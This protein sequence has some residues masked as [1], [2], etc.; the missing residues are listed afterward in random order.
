MRQFGKLVIH[1]PVLY[2]SR[3]YHSRL[4]RAC[5]LGIRGGESVVALAVRGQPLVC[6]A[7][8]EKTW[9]ALPYDRP[10]VNG[11]V[12][13]ALVRPL[14]D[15][16]SNFTWFGAFRA[17]SAPIAQRAMAG[18]RQVFM[19]T[20]PIRIVSIPGLLRFGDGYSPYHQ[21]DTCT[22]KWGQV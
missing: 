10:R 11:V 19:A 12:E 21:W 15:A 2:H 17:A 18:A 3:L 22:L 20:T 6:A 14:T 4:E 1:S 7:I 16:V 8:Q 13:D 5:D 9:V